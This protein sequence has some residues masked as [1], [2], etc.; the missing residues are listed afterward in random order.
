MTNNKPSGLLISFDGIDSSGKATQA[1]HL[2]ARLENNGITA[3]Q[4]TTPDYSTPSGQDL[5]KRL[6]GKIGHWASTPWPE[7]LRYFA[8]N[9][10]EHRGEVLDIIRRGGVVIYD[11]YVPSSLTFMSIEAKIEDPDTTSQQ[12][13]AIVKQSEYQAHKMPREDLSIFLDLSPK[14][15]AQ[16]L[17]NRKSIQRE[18]D[19]YTDHI[20]VQARLYQE[21]QNLIAH[22][23]SHYLVISCYH[24]HRLRP[25]EDIAHEIWTGII[26]KFPQLNHD[27]DES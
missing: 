10:A 9:R 15:A 14:I 8:D 13:Y 6:Q 23:P 16:L 17:H 21:Y 20:T 22:D 27:P 5:K 11:R 3:A 1:S 25:I 12:V 7:K 2:K 26:K 24:A 19:E 18:E 4:F